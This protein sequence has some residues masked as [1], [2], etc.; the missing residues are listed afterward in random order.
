M[1]HFSNDNFN[2]FLT[3]LKNL[4]KDEICNDFIDDENPLEDL[5]FVFNVNGV[6]DDYYDI[7]SKNLNDSEKEDVLDTLKTD[8]EYIDDELNVIICDDMDYPDDAIY[9]F[10]VYIENRNTGFKMLYGTYYP[11]GFETKY[12]I[13][14][15]GY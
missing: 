2:D 3:W 12:E 14:N 11:S 7:V 10:D 9:F 8:F 13:I 4:N 6:Q 5:W 15:E 1:E